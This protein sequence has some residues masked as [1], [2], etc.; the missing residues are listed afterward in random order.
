MPHEDRWNNRDS[1]EV[2]G[3]QPWTGQTIL[4][5]KTVEKGKKEAINERFLQNQRLGS[6]GGY[7]TFFYEERMEVEE[8]AFPISIITWKSYKVKRCT[9]NTLS[10]ECQAMI[11]GVGSP[12]WIRALLEETK[13][14]K[15]NL[16]HWEEQ[17]EATPFIA[18]TDSKSLYDTVS[19]CRNTAS[20]INDKRTAIDVTILP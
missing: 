1:Q 6:Q 14:T 19:K 11:Q 8:A 20:H 4:W 13:G 3:R 9:V 12:H 10:G 15:L 7:L 2:L 16:Q 17:V 18:I 5:K